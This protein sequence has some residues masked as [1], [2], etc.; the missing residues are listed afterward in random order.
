[1]IVTD[2][3]LPFV[4][5]NDSSPCYVSRVQRVCTTLQPLITRLPAQ[6]VMALLNAGLALPRNEWIKLEKRGNLGIS[7]LPEYRITPQSNTIPSPIELMV[8]RKPRATKLP[9]LP[10]N[11]RSQNKHNVHEKMIKHQGNRSESSIPCLIQVHPCMC[12]IPGEI[13]GNLE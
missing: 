13:N 6:E 1:M 10:S 7:G 2:F 3:G 12:K 5:R 11:N 9:Q 8:Q 4:I